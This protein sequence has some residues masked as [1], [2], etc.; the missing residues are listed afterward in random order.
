MNVKGWHGVLVVIIYAITLMVF[1]IWFSDKQKAKSSMKGFYLSGGLGS[2]LLFFTLFAT[3]YS[4][5]TVVG[6]PAR[7]YRLGYAWWQSVPFMIM[8]IVGYLVFAP[9][10]H[11]LAKKYNFITPADW[12]EKRFA[13]RAVTILGTVLMIYGLSNYLLEQLIAMGNA[14]S[15]LTAGAIPYLYGVIFLVVIMA[16]Y[17]WIGGMNAV[18]I[19]D[20]V[21]GIAIL[22][23]VIGF[24]I[25]AVATFGGPLSAANHIAETAPAKIGVP[26]IQTSINW[27]SMYILVGV[28]AA[29]YPHAIQRIYAAE[30]EHT[31]K[32]ALKR[33]AWMP[34][35]TT[36]LVFF[37][38]IIGIKA[39]P[40][41]NTAASEKLVGTMANAIASKSAFNYWMM[42]LLYTGV[43][44]AI[45]STTD[46]VLLSLSSLLSNDIYARFINPK[47]T[48]RA[49]VLWGKIV[50]LMLI[51]VLLLI[52]W[53]P[54]ATLYEI[55]VLKF[56]ILIQ[57][58]PAFLI[59]LY[60]KRMN[61]KAVLA[62]MIA[63]ATIAVYMVSTKTPTFHGIHAGVIGLFVNTTVSVIGSL[64]IPVS[65]TDEA[66]A[67]E[68][69]SIN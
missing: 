33:M 17:E 51:G 24:V 35:I 12:L 13:N 20:T 9:R 31:L 49:K 58:A 64:L 46:S 22:V 34:F 65:R 52:A 10:L 25:L 37:I 23:G 56:E 42:M 32:K 16:I 62:G 69:I 19:A 40:G 29:L 68:M 66:K 28:G 7:A 67:G 57:I 45:M 30:S 48:D 2:V 50:G 54:P 63:G 4:G 59:G 36:G 6:Y 53:K 47:A 27:I 18:A 43:V 41:L 55:F 5:N 15:G 44:G 26:P 60:W 61:S 11:I 1:S 38:G 21:N 3:Q 8:V 14:I 39:F